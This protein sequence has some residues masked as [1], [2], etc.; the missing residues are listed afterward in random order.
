MHWV[1]SSSDGSER[2]TSE[3]GDVVLAERPLGE[4]LEESLAAETTWTLK[5]AGMLWRDAETHPD[6]GAAIAAAEMSN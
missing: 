3:R 2:W 6:F 5:R 4:T 1:K